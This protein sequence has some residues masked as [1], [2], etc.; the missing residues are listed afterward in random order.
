MD[1]V[2]LP[3]NGRGFQMVAHLVHQDLDG[4]LAVVAV[5]MDEGKPHPVIQTVQPSPSSERPP[6]APRRR[7]TMI[8]LFQVSGIST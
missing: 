6:P 5:L 7:T 2:H 4:K 1:S 8:L 3:L